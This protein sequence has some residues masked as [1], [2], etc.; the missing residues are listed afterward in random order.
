MF[1]GELLPHQSQPIDV[2]LR[3]G[4]FWADIGEM[5][6]IPAESIEG[7]F[8]GIS[9]A[10]SRGY[11]YYALCLADENNE[12]RLLLSPTGHNICDV[13][14]L[15]YGRVFRTLFIRACEYRPPANAGGQ[16]AADM[17]KDAAVCR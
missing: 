11:P 2:R 5:D 4:L 7:E 15:L 13:V 14:R 10:N 8:R 17:D 6:A 1:D 9:R 3:N 16:E 12:Y